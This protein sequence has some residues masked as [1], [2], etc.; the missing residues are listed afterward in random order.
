MTE[1]GIDI[2]RQAPE[3]VDP[4]DSSR[5]DPE[6]RGLMQRK[7]TARHMVETVRN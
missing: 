7:A 4:I 3:S 2:S 5:I 1:T 6:D